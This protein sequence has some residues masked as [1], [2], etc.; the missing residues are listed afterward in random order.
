MTEKEQ[1]E[2]GAEGEGD[3]TLVSELVGTA[4]LVGRRGLPIGDHDGELS[5]D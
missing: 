4:Q 5:A 2:T 1:T 3:L